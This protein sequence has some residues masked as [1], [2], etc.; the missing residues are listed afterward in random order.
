MKPRRM[1]VVS[2]GGH[3]DNPRPPY[4]RI[5]PTAWDECKQH[6]AN[7]C[8]QNV[9]SLVGRRVKRYWSNGEVVPEFRQ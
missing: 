3:A 2:E 9:I 4:R 8:N 5:I 6:G 1:S 7:R